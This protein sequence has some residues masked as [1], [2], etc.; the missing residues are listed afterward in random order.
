M[1]MKCLLLLAV[2]GATVHS[3]LA[4]PRPWTKPGFCRSYE[5][6]RF[7]LIKDA[8]AY[9][10]RRYEEAWW[11]GATTSTGGSLSNAGL[12]LK[13]F[14]YIFGNNDKDLRLGMTV[15]VVVSHRTTNRTMAFYISSAYQN[16]P[17]PSDPAVVLEKRPAF[18]AFVRSFDGYA[19]PQ[20]YLAAYDALVSATN[21]T[22][23]YR[24]DFF[25]GVSYDQPAPYWDRSN[26]TEVWLVVR[27]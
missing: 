9:Q 13:L 6:P 24:T 26:H 10:V 21:N 2:V 25:Y 15:P 27:N 7:T 14:R 5:C 22:T 19:N 3:S 20:K 8:G 18:T 4:A 16:P 12:F 17:T 23:A 11:V 1:L